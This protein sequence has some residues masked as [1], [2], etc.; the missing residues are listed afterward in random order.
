MSA[1]QN[2]LFLTILR[3]SLM[4]QCSDITSMEFSSL[5][6]LPAVP[7]ITSLD[8]REVWIEKEQ[9]K[10]YFLRLEIYANFILTL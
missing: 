4:F 9:W 1:A 3:S 10:H 7:D 8:H 2:L 5:Q 6:Y